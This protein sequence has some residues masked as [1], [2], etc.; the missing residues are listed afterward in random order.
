MKFF[1]NVLFFIPFFSSCTLV[2]IKKKQQSEHHQQHFLAVSHDIS[3]E[4]NGG[5]HCEKWKMWLQ[6][7]VKKSHKHR[8]THAYNMAADANTFKAKNFGEL[9]NHSKGIVIS[10]DDYHCLDG[11]ISCTFLDE[12]KIYFNKLSLS[13]NKI[14]WMRVFWHEVFH[15]I[16]PQIPHISCRDCSDNK[17]ITYQECDKSSFSSYGIEL[18]WLAAHA[19]KFSSDKK[20]NQN[21]EVALKDLKNRICR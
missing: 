10:Y 12:K 21:N 16:Y 2:D 6:E 19:K 14:E 11:Q 20:F 15:L 4:C 17:S 8:I 13:L 5:D 9:L 18:F 3:L 7:L 1:C